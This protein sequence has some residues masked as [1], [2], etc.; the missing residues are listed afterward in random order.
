MSNLASHIIGLSDEEQVHIQVVANCLATHPELQSKLEAAEREG[1][2]DGLPPLF[3]TRLAW[4]RLVSEGEAHPEIQRAVAFTDETGVAIEDIIARHGWPFRSVIGESAALHL[5]ALVAHADERNTF[6]R[7]A[8][9]AM[10]AAVKAGEADPR[11]FAHIYDR[12][13]AVARE[14]QLYGSLIAPRDGEGIVLWPVRDPQQLDTRRR[15]I[16]LPSL[17]EDLDLYRCGAVM[18]PFMVPTPP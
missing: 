1:I 13:C 17:D 3:R 2:N 14:P 6:R 12:T 16:G 4:A 9:G 8:L 10:S 18:G 7:K 15:G 5:S 11:H